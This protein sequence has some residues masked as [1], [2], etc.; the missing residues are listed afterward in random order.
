VVAVTTAEPQNGSVEL[1]EHDDKTISVLRGRELVGFAF[2]AILDQPDGAWFARFRGQAAVKLWDRERA[3]RWLVGPRRVRV[4]GDL[5]HGRI[6]DGAV[7]VGRGAPGLPASPYANRHKVGHC[8]LCDAEH[9]RVAAVDA[10]RRDL[11]GAPDLVAAARRE[12]AGRDLACW[13][14]LDEGPCHA[15][16]LLELVSV[17]LADEDAPPDSL[18]T[19]SSPPSNASSSPRRETSE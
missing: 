16:A 3:L 17:H 11:D 19:G 2:P 9:D 15:D 1:V 14:R 7:Y 12:L 4:Q 13:C 6:P 8:R 5:Y 10:Y 18:R